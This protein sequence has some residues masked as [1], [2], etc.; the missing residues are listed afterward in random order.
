MLQNLGVVDVDAAAVARIVAVEETHFID[1]KA[2]EL[3]AAKLGVHA[4]AFANSAGGEIYVG[5]DDPTGG[6]RAWR[7]FATV[8][9]ANGHVQVLHEMF[10]GNNICTVEFVRGAG[11]SGF[12]LHVII[13]KSREIV[14]TSGRSE[15]HTSELQSPC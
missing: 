3:S 14:S 4:S 5:I 9:E 11:V 13:E 10:Q 1:V 12:A 7:A 8:E 6:P 2:I 15:E